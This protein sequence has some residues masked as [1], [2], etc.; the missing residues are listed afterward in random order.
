VPTVPVGEGKGRA[1]EEWRE[2]QREKSRGE[3]RKEQR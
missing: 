1:G 3:K 2:K